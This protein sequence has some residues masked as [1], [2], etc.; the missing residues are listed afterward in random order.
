MH[1]L[2][3]S[4]ISSVHTSEGPRLVSAGELATAISWFPTFPLDLQDGVRPRS[5]FTLGAPPGR[6]QMDWWWTGGHGVSQRKLGLACFSLSVDVICSQGPSARAGGTSG[7][8]STGLSAQRAC[9][10]DARSPLAMASPAPSLP[11]YRPEMAV[12]MATLLIQSE[13]M[14]AMCFSFP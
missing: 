12:S 13:I 4:G 10:P 1:S 11:P 2:A 3:P 14:K 9:S 8:C 6:R 5:T 7:N